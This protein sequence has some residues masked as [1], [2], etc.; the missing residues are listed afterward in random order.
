MGRVCT[1]S[2]AQILRQVCPIQQMFMDT[3]YRTCECLQAVLPDLGKFP[4][5]WE[6]LGK[7]GEIFYPFGKF[8]KWEKIGEI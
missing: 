2:A 5:F 6:I 4:N 8:P 1:L 7:S 3:Q